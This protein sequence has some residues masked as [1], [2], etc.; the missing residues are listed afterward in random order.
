MKLI[1][2]YCAFFALIGLVLSPLTIAHASPPPADHM[3][4]SAPFAHE[5]SHL[6]PAAKRLAA[7]DWNVGEPRTVRTIYFT[8]ND[9][10]YN[11]QAVAWIQEDLRKAQAFFAEQMQAHGYGDKTFRFE[12]DAQGEPLVHRVDGQHPESHYFLNGFFQDYHF[13]EFENSTF[14]LNEN[15]Y[16]VYAGLSVGDDSVTASAYR[17]SKR[18]GTVNYPFT[19]YKALE[20]K[21]L[22]HELGHAF[23]LGHD[24]HDGAYIMSYGPGENQLSACSAQFLS[25][26]PYF[27]SDIPLE[28]VSPARIRLLS[29]TEYSAGLQSVPVQLEISHSDE[30]HQMILS[31]GSGIDVVAC[32]GIDGKE[33]RVASEYKGVFTPFGFINLPDRVTHRIRSTV[34]DTK[35]N[36]TQEEFRYREMSP[37]R[38]ATLQDHSSQV[39]FSPDGTTL[40]STGDKITLWDV[41]TLTKTATLDGH[42]YG[43]NSVS[44]SPDGTTLA[45]TGLFDDI[46]QLWD[47]AT[48]KHT[49]TLYDRST[50][51]S[52]LFSPDGTILA[53]GND[54]EITLWDVATQKKTTT[55]KAHSRWVDL[56][57]F[58]PDGS[59]LASASLTSEIILWNVATQTRRKT[60]PSE[61]LLTGLSFSPDGNILASADLTGEVLLWDVDAQRQQL[62]TCYHRSQIGSVSFSP[63]SGIL[64]SGGDDGQILLWDAYT[65]EIIAAFPHGNPIGSM[66]F[67]PKLG[68]MAS[69]GNDGQILLW[70]VSEWTGASPLTLTTTSGEGDSPVNVR[71]T[72]ELTA[73][74]AYELTEATLKRGVGVSVVLGSGYEYEPSIGS[75]P[76]AVTVSGIP[77]VTVVAWG[78]LGDGTI[79]VDIHFS[80]ALDGDGQ[81]TFTVAA[82][83]IADYNGPPV[84]AQIPVTVPQENTATGLSITT[85]PAP[86][87][88]ATLSGS[89]VALILSG[90]TYAPDIANKVTVSGIPG[91]TA[92]IIFRASDTQILVKLNF[93]GVLDGDAQL[94][95]TVAADAIADYNGPPL[96]A[97]IPV[98]TTSEGDAETAS[99]GDAETAGDL[100]DLLDAFGGGKRAALPDSPQLAQNAPNPFNSQTVLT[101]FLPAA[102]SV[103]LAVF[104]L[105]GQRVAL[106]QQGPQR[107]GYHQLRWNGRDDAGRPVASGLYLYRLMTDETILTRK[108][109]LLR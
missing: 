53:S 11:P 107:A 103:R 69:G 49:A 19:D 7:A 106:L 54:G 72:P 25:V 73:H 26:H 20:W 87:T 50:V 63:N 34:V 9:R 109:I 108:L 32:R 85:T 96:T 71:A 79:V 6:L 18:A 61:H 62:G 92:G 10:P 8:P 3:H 56:L 45:S 66:S 95:F 83:A 57:S 84:S 78:L 27:D 46:V 28:D 37:Y 86:L 70:D 4:L 94:T 41:A 12:T 30:L 52:V 75:I 58:S 104:T 43:V 59:I 76:E 101:Y 29:P 90:L 55:L 1:A 13:E 68:V 14:D 51:R 82:D 21:V 42:E 64:A 48:L 93:S 40:A 97:Q 74:A 44:F 39:L 88:E 5:H 91:A 60:F 23:G 99:E 31:S 102:G 47:V 33:D 80:G 38:L 65:Q 36:V 89:T 67:S 77:S 22:A 17:R 16:V 81:L 105:T 100:Q 35:G 98:S 15:T 24:F 2:F